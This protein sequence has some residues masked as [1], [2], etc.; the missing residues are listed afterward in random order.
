MD[1]CKE[2]EVYRL[3]CLQ[4]MKTIKSRDVEF[5]KDSIRVGNDLDMCLSGSNKD[6]MVVIVDDSLKSPTC[7]DDE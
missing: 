4:T 6:H 7:D 5:M 2:T 1:Y 3:M